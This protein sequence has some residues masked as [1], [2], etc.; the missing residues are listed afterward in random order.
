MKSLESLY[1]LENKFYDQ[2]I[3]NKMNISNNSNIKGFNDYESKSKINI[4]KFSGLMDD[5]K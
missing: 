3:E 4:S 2:L 5:N 1:S